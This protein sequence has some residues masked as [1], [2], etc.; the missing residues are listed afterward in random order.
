MWSSCSFGSR[1]QEK[2]MVPESVQGSRQRNTKLNY[3]PTAQEQWM[4]S[5]SAQGRGTETENQ[6]K[7]LLA[8]PLLC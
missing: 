3:L 8:V 5:D 1:A 7:N 4:V 6:M 2:W